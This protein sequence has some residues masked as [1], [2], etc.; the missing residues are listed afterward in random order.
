[1]SDVRKQFVLSLNS[2]NRWRW[3]LFDEGLKPVAGSF[4]TYRSY[5]EC[6]ASTRQ[7]IGVAQDAAIW[8]AEHQRWDESARVR[9]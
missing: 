6:V 9:A 8:D 1:M 4:G 3:F 2:R 5:D 7:A